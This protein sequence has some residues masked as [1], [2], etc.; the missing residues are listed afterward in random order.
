M[1]GVTGA[2]ALCLMLAA[3]CAA[4]QPVAP[5]GPTPEQQRAEAAASRA[6]GTAQRAEAAASRAEAAA[7]RAEQAAQRVEALV[8]RAEAGFGRRLR[9]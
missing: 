5:T 8:Q 1:K 4:R 7:S 2:F 3:G 6:E 9:K